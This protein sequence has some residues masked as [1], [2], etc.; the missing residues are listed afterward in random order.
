MQDFELKGLFD[1]KFTPLIAEM[2][3]LS[4][5][6]ISTCRV[7]NRLQVCMLLKFQFV[8]FGFLQ[9]RTLAHVAGITPAV[10][11]QE[12]IWCESARLRGGVN[13][14]KIN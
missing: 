5:C 13:K 4:L 2:L 3:H 8:W 12:M 14:K 1:N 10:V 9:S 6:L 7:K 11:S